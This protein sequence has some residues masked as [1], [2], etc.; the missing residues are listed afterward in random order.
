MALFIIL[1]ISFSVSSAQDNPNKY[2]ICFVGVDARGEH[3]EGFLF[4]K[5]TKVNYQVSWK[6]CDSSGRDAEINTLNYKIY[7]WAEKDSLSDHDSKTS[8]DIGGGSMAV[9]ENRLAKTQYIFRVDGVNNNGRLVVKSQIARSIFPTPK[10][11]GNGTIK[12]NL[13]SFTEFM[14]VYDESTD[15]GRA[16][17]IL[18]F[19]FFIIACLFIVRCFWIMRPTRL[20]PTEMELK[21]KIDD[22]YDKIYTDGN[23][24]PVNPAQTKE[25]LQRLMSTREQS[26][27]VHARKVLGKLPFYPNFPKRS[28]EK[29]TDFGDLPTITIVKDGLKQHKNIP[30]RQCIQEYLDRTIEAEAARLK[31]RGFIDWLWSLG[32][33]EP[34]LGLYGTVTGLVS[35][36]ANYGSDPAKFAPGIS[37]ALWTTVY[38]LT[39]GIILMLAH[40]YFSNKLDRVIT[41]WEEMS[42]KLAKE[43]DKL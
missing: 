19:L 28:H 43:C 16:S 31:K 29:L 17:F 7:C 33:T 18:I 10:G 1:I 42:L 14:K 6:L 38:G 36:F 35:A 34:L 22:I 20:F 39:T 21:E 5:E 11:G 40:Y 41:T 4:W 24:S 9:F 12:V 30:D 23:S 32:Y 2:Q 13:F 27:G 25:L 8:L 37:E 15:L 3:S 26:W